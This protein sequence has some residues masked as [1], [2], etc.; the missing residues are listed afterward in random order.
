MRVNELLCAVLLF[1]AV[2]VARA[3]CKDGT[4]VSCKLNGKTG[5]KECINGRFTPCIVEPDPPATGTAKPRYY[6]LTVIYSPPGTKGGGSDSSVS[7]GQ[8]SSSGTTVSSSNSFKKGTKV[9]VEVSGGI[10]GNGGGAGG[11]FGISRSTTNSSELEVKK[12]AQTEITVKGPGIDGLDHDRDQIWLWLNPRLSITATPTATKWT[13]AGGQTADIQF[14][15][16]GHLKNPSLMPPGVA[17]RLQ[18]NGITPADYPDILRADPFA[19]GGLVINSARYLPLFT[20]F[21]YEPPFAEGDP[22]TTF[23]ATL[24][25]S[26]TQTTAKETEREYEVGM[27]LSAE[28][29]VPGF[30]KLS[31]KSET[32]WTWTNKSG[33]ST[34]AGTSESAKVTI[35][36]PSFGYKGPTDI[37]VY[38][39]VLYKTFLFAPILTPPQFGGVLTSANGRPVPGQEVR[40]TANGKTYRTFTNRKGE[41]RFPN[42]FVGSVQIRSGAITK[43]ANIPRNSSRLDLQVQ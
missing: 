35:G 3:A 1:S 25:S 40:I 41:Y 28:G 15:F 18:A 10:L 16:V 31:L 23:Q 17:Q 12:S 36:G 37:A 39:D 26:S 11:S 22:V 5:T 38:Y 42:R 14:V 27:T 9:S 30:A 21:P 2:P 8:G 34:A 19:N 43:R 32:S 24:D 33:T 29:G 6:V 13:V 20:T 7:Y 4:T